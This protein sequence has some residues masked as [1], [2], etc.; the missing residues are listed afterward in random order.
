M[1]WEELIPRPTAPLRPRA[2]GT[3]LR[4]DPP[5]SR[6]ARVL[7]ACLAC[8]MLAAKLLGDCFYYCF[9]SFFNLVFLLAALSLT[10]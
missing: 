5:R 7:A 3:Q 2:A 1:V 10:H 4:L 9:N 6:G 8:G